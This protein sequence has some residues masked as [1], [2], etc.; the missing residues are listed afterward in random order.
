[1]IRNNISSSRRL[2]D[3]F[4]SSQQPRWPF[5]WIIIRYIYCTITFVLQLKQIFIKR[6]YAT[7][8]AIF[9]P[10]RHSLLRY[11]FGTISSQIEGT[12]SKCLEKKTSSR[13]KRNNKSNKFLVRI[14]RY[15]VQMTYRLWHQHFLFSKRENLGMFRRWSYWH[16]TNYRFKNKIAIP[17]RIFLF[18]RWKGFSSPALE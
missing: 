9:E 6:D 16:R 2:H 11:Q 13:K 14:I 18:D 5:P 3:T 17:W 12:F 10:R 15:N 8:H 1:V 7:V 4:S